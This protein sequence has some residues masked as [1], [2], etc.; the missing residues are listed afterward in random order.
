MS[1][2]QIGPGREPGNDAQIFHFNTCRCNSL[3]LRACFFMGNSAPAIDQ[4]AVDT[5]PG[6]GPVFRNIYKSDKGNAFG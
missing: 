2:G 6:D 3:L 4:I 5:L 1:I